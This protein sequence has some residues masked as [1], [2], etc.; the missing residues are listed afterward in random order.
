MSTKEDIDV[1]YGL[2]ADFYRLWL[3][4]RMTYTC[5]LFE[6]GDETLEEAQDKKLEHHYRAAR[7]KKGGRVLDIGCGWGSNLEFLA[8]DKGV[9]DVV[10]ITLSSEQYREILRRELPRTTVECISYVDYQPSEPFDA[11]ISIGMFEHVATP[12]Q[13][14]SGESVEIYRDYFKRAWEWSKPGSWFS[15]QTVVGAKIPRGKAL[16]DLA[17]GTSNI[18]PGAIS[19]RMDVIHKAVSPYWEV[20]ELFTRREHYARTTHE[21]LTRL[22]DN[23]ALIEE[24]WGVK[25]FED[26]KRYLEICVMVFSEGYQSL[27]QFSLR[28]IG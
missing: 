22:R 4:R 10:G 18:F 20:M 14:R 3:D 24:R 27:A 12:E 23:Q 7:V 15:L 11:I 26:Y 8:R 16:R 28:R 21:W 17:W 2:N 1:T 13:A 19:P 25:T 5:A 9:R 6:T